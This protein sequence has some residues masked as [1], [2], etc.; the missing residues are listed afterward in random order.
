M[1]MNRPLNQSPPSKT[2]LA[3]MA[4]ALAV[5]ALIGSG[6]AQSVFTNSLEYVDQAAF[7]AEWT[8]VG[9]AL[10]LDATR[11][12]TPGGAKCVFQ[13]TAAGQAV[14]PTSAHVYSEDLYFRCWFIDAG[15]SRCLVEAESMSNDTT[16]S[17][18]LQKLGIGRYNTITGSKYYGRLAYN[19]SQTTSEGGTAWNGQYF[20]LGGAAN[21]SS[22]WHKFEIVGLRQADMSIKYRFYVDGVLGGACTDASNRQFN[23][24]D[25]G[26]NTTQTGTGNGADD[27]VMESLTMLP[28]IDT[29]PANLTVNELQPASFSV[30][31][32]AGGTLNTYALNTLK[33]QWQF[34]NG[35]GFADI[36]GATNASY[37]I[38]SATIAANQGSY[39]CIA[40]DAYGRKPATS[41]PAYLTVNPVANPV[42]DSCTGGGVVNVGGSATFTVTA[43]GTPPLT[44]VWKRNGN[45]VASGTDS[46]YTISPVAQ[47]DTGTYT[48]VI[49]NGTLPD[50]TS[51][52]MILT[53][54][55]PPALTAP[56]A[57]IGI[58]TVC[59]FRM[60]AT[61]DL[62]TESTLIRDFE[63][64]GSGSHLMF[65]QPSFSGTTSGQLDLVAGQNA[66]VTTSAMPAGHLSPHALKS[67]W[68]WAATPGPGT[69]R[70]TTASP[71]TGYSPI[72]SYTNRLR[73]DICSDRSIKVG[74]GTRD[75][76]PTGAI[77]ASD[78]SATSGTQLEWIGVS[79]GSGATPSKT[80]TAGTWETLDFDPVNDPKNAN[81]AWG[82]GNGVLNTTTG[83]GALEHLFLATVDALPNDN[84]VYLDNF[85]VVASKPITFTL[86]SGPAGATI[87]QYSGLIDWVPAALGNASFTVT[88]TDA[89]GLTDTKTYAVAVVPSPAT[90]TNI[91]YTAGDVTI[92]GTGAPH[93]NFRLKSSSDLTA[94][95]SSWTQEE[96]DTTKTGSFNW[97]LLNPDKQYFRV[98]SYGD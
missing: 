43:H 14:R 66:S 25:V 54:N 63:G 37:S 77:G 46:F 45:Q 4:G 74:L 7:D 20:Q 57:T 10:T 1:K 33:Y 11:N 42:F 51:T 16:Y 81:G 22:G 93:Q 28:Q 3:L 23:W 27:I 39:Q 30:V 89:Y 26:I 75:T 5:V 47:G 15:G 44:Y 21:T 49:Q 18:T 61:D 87:D 24:V 17:G 59:E 60:H 41:A 76:S 50:A 95:M 55:M 19:T 90:I 8:A 6:Q 48:C 84:N 67:S 73:F 92:K 97:T 96:V 53:V 65:N 58:G 72:I 34:D 86:V 68:T 13:G 69:L 82:L 32:S 2:R 88:A 79:G 9:T 64:Y 56:A 38:A 36:A 83:K 52:P 35:S 40:T 29:P 98:E 62:S 91:T 12:H 71:I 85:L 94:P 31:A 80:L 70:L 78:T